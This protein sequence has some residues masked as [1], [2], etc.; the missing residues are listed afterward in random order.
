MRCE[1]R[2]IE[3]VQLRVENHNLR[4]ELLLWSVW[5]IVMFCTWMAVLGINLLGINKWR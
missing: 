2:D 4:K 5:G 1:L 3:I